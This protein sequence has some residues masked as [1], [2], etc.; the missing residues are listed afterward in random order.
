MIIET[1]LH[2][3]TKC[4]QVVTWKALQKA[5]EQEGE[6]EDRWTRVIEAL[7]SHAIHIKREFKK[8]DDSLIVY[9]DVPIAGYAAVPHSVPSALDEREDTSHLGYAESL[10]DR[11]RL[12]QQDFNSNSFKMTSQWLFWRGRYLDPSLIYELVNGGK[13]LVPVCPVNSHASLQRLHGVPEYGADTRTVSRITDI[14]IEEKYS[15]ETSLYRGSLCSSDGFQERSAR[16]S[17]HQNKRK[18]KEKKKTGSRDYLEIDLHDICDITAIGLMGGYPRHTYA[19]T[20][21]THDHQPHRYNTYQ[22]SVRVIRD[23]AELA[24]VKAFSIQFRDYRDGKWYPYERTFPGNSDVGT[25]VINKVSIRTRYLRLTVMDYERAKEMRVQVYGR[26]LRPIDASRKSIAHLSTTSNGE[27]DAIV[28]YAIYP[29]IFRDYSMNTSKIYR[30]PCCYIPRV[31]NSRARVL[32]KA[33][34]DVKKIYRNGDV[35]SEDDID[36]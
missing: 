6:E 9:Y 19:F 25:E 22:R 30:C 33:S 13:E 3:A 32:R 28:R 16:S 10:S 17:S 15:E 21:N 12:R 31:T 36:L 29:P 5:N 2:N 18:S 34:V 35:D 8:Q 14:D 1:V 7:E 27:K 23:N 26:S 24:W 4:K 20:A 11:A